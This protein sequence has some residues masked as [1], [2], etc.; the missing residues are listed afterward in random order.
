MGA[1]SRGAKNAFRNSVRTV[2]IIFILGLSI[3]MSLIMFMSYRAVENK[4]DNIKSS[5]GNTITISPAGV[6]GFEGGGELLTQEDVDVIKTI[7]GVMIVSAVLSDRLDSDSS[8]LVSAIEPGSFGRRQQGFE[9]GGSNRQMPENFSMP[10]SVTGTDDLS[11]V[12]NLNVSSL[13]II[14]GEKF[15]GQSEELVALVGNDL[16]SKNNLTIGATFT[17]YNQPILVVGIFD[18]GNT[19]A[20]STAFMPLKTLQ[21][22]SDQ[23]D[24]VNSITTQVDS[25]DNVSSVESAIKTALGEKADVISQQDSSSEAVKP[26]ENIRNISIYSMVGSLVAGAIVIF[27][28]ML[29]IARERKKEIGVLK[30]IGSTNSNIVMQF[31]SES[32]VLTLLGS[33]MGIVL[34]FVFSNPVLKLLV[35]NNQSTVANNIEHGHGGGM[36]GMAERFVPGVQN[37][38][39]NISAVVSWDM[40]LYGL[41]IALI[42]AITGSSIPAYII[43]KIRPAEVMR[44][45]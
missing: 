15:D 6:R 1:I 37:S 33:T 7:S 24:Q 12:S 28:T 3:A 26:L 30:A 20:N 41:I 23:Q 8:N 21:K 17:A 14:S 40:I 19:F 34:G 43:A 22:I 25:I 13:N 2:S 10:V 35:S 44:S 38:L 32:M 42:I 18:G 31:I 16:A 45:E 27:L 9:S 36:R 11:I 39:D 29:M 5:I 4:I